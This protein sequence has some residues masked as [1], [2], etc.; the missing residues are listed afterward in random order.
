LPR[1]EDAEPAR[2]PLDADGLLS[3]AASLF[4]RARQRH[5]ET[6]RIPLGERG[7]RGRRAPAT[8]R[9]NEHDPSVM[10]SRWHVVQNMRVALTSSYAPGLARIPISCSRLDRFRHPLLLRLDRPGPPRWSP[11]RAPRRCSRACRPARSVATRHRPHD[12]QLAL[13]VEV[14]ALLAG[15]SLPVEKK[16]RRH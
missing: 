16:S 14:V 13:P 12:D 10:I 8:G 4:D 9:R 5:Y 1:H 2:R 15:K 3:R 6:V 7:D 11:A